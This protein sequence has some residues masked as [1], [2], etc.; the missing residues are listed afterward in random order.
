LVKKSYLY[1]G[2]PPLTTINNPISVINFRPIKI[3]K[4]EVSLIVKEIW[5]KGSRNKLTSLT[6]AASIYSNEDNITSS[7]VVKK[8]SENS[9]GLIYQEKNS[10]KVSNV[11]KLSLVINWISYLIFDKDVIKRLLH[12]YVMKSELCDK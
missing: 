7:K 5:S 1:L 11:S 9:K 8:A 4:N 10:K 2:I 6:K 3:E 12:V